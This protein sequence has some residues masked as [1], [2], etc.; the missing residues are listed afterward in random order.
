[1]SVPDDIDKVPVKIIR[2]TGA[3]ESFILES[4]LP[5]CINMGINKGNKAADFV[6]SFAQS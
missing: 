6:H 3:S 2:D 5:F 4:T 1:M